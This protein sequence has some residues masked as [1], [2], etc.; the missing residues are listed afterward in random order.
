MLEVATRGRRI[1]KVYEQDRVDILGSGCLIESDPESV[2]MEER[3]SGRK[4]TKR[5]LYYWL[6]I[7]RIQDDQSVDGHFS[8]DAAWAEITLSV[9][10]SFLTT[11]SHKI[12]SLLSDIG[13]PTKNA[14]HYSFI[15]NIVC[16]NQ[17]DFPMSLRRFHWTSRLTSPPTITSDAFTPTVRHV[18]LCRT[19]L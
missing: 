3:I 9:S 18:F 14:H 4:R 19:N 16:F 2:D 12:S 8:Q 7:G 13:Q 5:C 17:Y 6:D 11:H 15:S 10:L 1:R